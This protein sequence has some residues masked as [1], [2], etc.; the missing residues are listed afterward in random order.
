MHTFRIV[1]VEDDGPTRRRLR[2]ALASDPTFDV[3]AADCLAAA[4]TA[5]A[6]QVPDALVTDLELPDGHGSTLAAEVSAAHPSVAILVIS[7]LSD[8]HSVVS[9]IASGARGYVLKDALP[10]DLTKTVRQVLA[11]DSPLSPSVARYLLRRIQPHEATPKPK[12][13]SGR[14]ADKLAAAEADRI[15]LTQREVDIL[16]GIAKGLS[17][18][19]IAENLGLSQKTVPNYIKSVYRKLKV[20]SR[21]EAVFEAISHNL[22]RM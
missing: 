19:E 13:A 20:N 15:G 21:G 22:I 14:E 16:W 4:R 17:Y 8:E 18:N 5:I 1:L 9:A 11:G 10:A 7:V 12:P 6:E 3:V 2:N